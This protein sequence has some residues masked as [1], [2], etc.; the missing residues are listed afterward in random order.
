MDFRLKLALPDNFAF[1]LRIGGANIRPVSPYIAFAVAVGQVSAIAVLVHDQCAMEDVEL[2]KDQFVSGLIEHAGWSRSDAE[3]YV[4]V[5]APLI[6]IE[7]PSQVAL[8]QCAQLRKR[9]PRVRVAPLLYAVAD[10]LVYQI[11][12][13]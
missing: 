4:A 7:E 1:V 3:E 9:F 10:G 8:R 2:R 13:S 11:R 12:S 6:R 5:C